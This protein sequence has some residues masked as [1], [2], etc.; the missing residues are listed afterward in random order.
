MVITKVAWK[1]KK[2]LKT[3]VATW[4]S[5]KDNIS[6]VVVEKT[7]ADHLENGVSVFTKTTNPKVVVQSENV[8]SSVLFGNQNIFGHRF[9]RSICLI[10]LAVILLMIFF[11]TL[12]TYN[13]VNELYFLLLN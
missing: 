8:D 4:N 6:E 2:T 11:L 7:K 5:K 12:K 10:I 9:L 1:N 13:T 3:K